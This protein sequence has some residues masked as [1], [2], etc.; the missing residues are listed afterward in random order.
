MMGSGFP[1]E[2]SVFDSR[3]INDIYE[4][5][6]DVYHRYP[7]P[8]VIGYSGGKDSTAVLQLVW[9]ALETLAP[10]QRQKPV[11]VIASDTQVETPVIVDYIDNTL[12]RINKAAE[13]T[14]MPFRAEKVL[15]TLNNS[16]WVNLIGRGYPAPTSRFRWCTD[17]LKIDPANR[18]IEAKVAQYGEVIMVLGVRKS[19]SSTRMQLMNTYQVKGHI[20]RRHS[21]LSGAYVYAPVAD[22]STQDVWTYLLQ[23]KSPWG[24]KNRDLVTL[25]RNASGGECP[26]VIDDTTPTCGNSRFGCWVC[27]VATRDSSMEALVDRGEEWLEPLLEFREW[28]ATTIDPARK[29][30]FRDI[31]GRDGRVILKKDG[32]PAARTYK[33]ES[34]KQMLEKVLRAQLLVRKNGPDVGATLISEEELHEIRR[35]W[36]TER[37]DWEDSVPQIF[38]Q[39]NG[40]DLDWP[41]D[42][43]GQFDSDQKALLASICGEYEVPFDLV[44][45]LLEAERN[46]NGPARR[47]GIQK[48]IGRVLAQEWRVEEEIVAE[49][50]WQMRLV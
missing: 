20:L 37:Q 11:F 46:A 39:A 43:N 44:A 50:Q 29:R 28:L 3:A 24:S 15:P 26:L 16:F 2:H 27:T 10:E 48:S 31:K 23:V 7:Q 47:T 45:K 18:F 1:N 40:F 22:F 41:S 17:R 35:L 12:R 34:S 8:W 4:E 42:D 13:R 25:Y 9:K 49:N 32:T 14:G 19:E 30:E 5:I 6:R 21:S 38:R 33:L 36:R